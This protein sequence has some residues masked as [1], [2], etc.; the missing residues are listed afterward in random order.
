MNQKA[1]R[2]RQGLLMITLI[3][4]PN[5][6]AS[7]IVFHPAIVYFKPLK[8]VNCKTMLTLIIGH[9]R[10]KS[11]LMTDC[12]ETNLSEIFNLSI[13]DKNTFKRYQ[14]LPSELKLNSELWRQSWSQ[15]YLKYVEKLLLTKKYA[16]FKVF[17]DHIIHSQEA[18]KL[19]KRMHP[20]VFSIHRE[21]QLDAIKSMLLAK[22]R[23]FH[24][25]EQIAYEPFSVAEDEFF[26]AYQSCVL[27]YQILKKLFPPDWSTTY[28]TFDP[29][30]FHCGEKLPNTQAQNSKEAFEHIL[31]LREVD[32]WYQNAV[33]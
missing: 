32:Q 9:E 13:I 23:G 16:V 4:Y 27:D 33:L 12:F 3:A 22:K 2:W 18:I 20:R 31:N 29:S 15:E 19:I 6:S 28:E 10:S 26:S 25:T 7:D 17:L 30:M 21:N 24:S 8:K 1:L 5:L 14:V 11:N